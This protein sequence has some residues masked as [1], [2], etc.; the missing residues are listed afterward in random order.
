[1]YR[2]AT[3]TAEFADCIVITAPPSSKIAVDIASTTTSAICQG[4]VPIVEINKSPMPMPVAVSAIVR[5]VEERAMPVDGMNSR[6][7]KSEQRL[8]ITHKLKIVKATN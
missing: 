2:V 8:A 5:R 3:S 7:T 4:P 1:M 6:P